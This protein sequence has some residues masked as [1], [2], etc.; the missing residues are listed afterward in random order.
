MNVARPSAPATVRWTPSGANHVGWLVVKPSQSRICRLLWRFAAAVSSLLWLP[1]SVRG[2]AAG[3]HVVGVRAVGQPQHADHALRFCLGHHLVDSVGDRGIV[4]TGHHDHRFAEP[5]PQRR[6]HQRQHTDR[7]G[8]ETAT[9]AG[10][11]QPPAA[12]RVEGQL[13]RV[14]DDRPRV[15][16]RCRP[17]HASHRRV[18]DQ[19]HRR[20][21]GRRRGRGDGVGTD[22]RQHCTEHEDDHRNEAARHRVESARRRSACSLSWTSSLCYPIC[23]FPQTSA[24][25]IQPRR[26]AG[27]T[28]AE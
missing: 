13:V 2:E 12:L 23:S 14:A 28:A 8:T 18:T 16:G 5:A 17:G 24:R 19:R 1:Y 21:V 3:Q 6:S 25:H 7:H 26:S 4:V 15:V 11:H 22:D 27:R 20:S 10:D 9:A